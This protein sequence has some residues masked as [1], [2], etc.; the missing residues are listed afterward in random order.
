MASG[1]HLFRG[2]HVGIYGDG[3]VFALVQNA[4]GLHRNNRESSHVSLGPSRQVMGNTVYR[5][6]FE[7]VLPNDFGSILFGVA[8]YNG[9]APHTWFQAEAT[10]GDGFINIAWHTVVDF[11]LHK[12]SGQQVGQL[13]YSEH[14]E[15]QG[16]ALVYEGQ[17]PSSLLFGLSVA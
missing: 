7:V 15:K 12:I 14:T 3:G 8:P 10:S 9:Q 13:G 5:G 16:R 2:S 11:G 17:L 6:Q 1:A 4:P